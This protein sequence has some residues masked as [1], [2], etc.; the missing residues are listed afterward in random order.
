VAE[1]S[2]AVLLPFGVGFVGTLR[3]LFLARQDTEKLTR[4]CKLMGH[5]ERSEASAVENKSRSFAREK[6]ASSG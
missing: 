2:L 4:A 5:A 3:R 6:H 1:P